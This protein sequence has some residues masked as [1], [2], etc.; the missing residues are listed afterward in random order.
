MD[1]GI[2]QE[3]V[4]AHRWFNLAA[5]AVHNPSV[6]TNPLIQ[7]VRV[8]YVKGGLVRLPWMLL[9]VLPHQDVLA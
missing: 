4:Q 5:E 2:S 7:E 3:D 1:Q 6:T 8:V 9:R